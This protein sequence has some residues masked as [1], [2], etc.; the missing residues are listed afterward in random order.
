[1]LSTKVIYLF[2]TYVYKEDLALNTLQ[3]LI[4]PKQTKLCVNEKKKKKKKY[5]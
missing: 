5:C 1:M 2:N 3:G 4:K